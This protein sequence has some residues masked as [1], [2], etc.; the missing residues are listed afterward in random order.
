MIQPGQQASLHGRAL[1]FYDLQPS[2][3]LLHPKLV[4]LSVN[5]DFFNGAITGYLRFQTLH[6]MDREGHFDPIVVTGP[7]DARSSGLIDEQGLNFALSPSLPPLSSTTEPR[8]WEPSLMGVTPLPS[9]QSI[10][11]PCA[12]P[13]GFVVPQG[14]GNLQ[15]G[16]QR[17]LFPSAL[18]HPNSNCALPSGNIFTTACGEQIYY[19]TDDGPIVFSPGQEEARARFAARGRVEFNNPPPPQA[20]VQHGPHGVTLASCNAMRPLCFDAHANQY[21]LSAEGHAQLAEEQ[22]C[23]VLQRSQAPSQLSSLSA[24]TTFEMGSQQVP[25]QQPPQQQSVQQQRSLSQHSER[26]SCAPSPSNRNVR[27]RSN[28]PPPLQQQQQ[29]QQPDQQLSQQQQCMQ[30]PQAAVPQLAPQHA[31]AARFREAGTT[32]ACAVPM[33]PHAQPRACSFAPTQPN[34]Q[35]L[36]THNM[37]MSG[38]APSAPTPPAPPPLPPPVPPVPAMG[39]PS[40]PPPSQG[41]AVSPAPQPYVASLLS[42]LE[43]AGQTASISTLLLSCASALLDVGMVSLLFKADGTPDVHL[44][45]AAVEDGLRAIA[46]SHSPPRPCTDL[47][48]NPVDGTVYQQAVSAFRRFYTASKN[49]TLPPAQLDTTPPQPTP[50]SNAPVQPQQALAPSRPSRPVASVPADQ[51]GVAVHT[52]LLLDRVA[53]DTTDANQMEAL[54]HLLKSNGPNDPQFQDA[55]K[56]ASPNVSALL[57]LDVELVQPEGHG[58]V[59]ETYMYARVLVKA[60]GAAVREVLRE[61]ERMLVPANVEPAP[62]FE[63]FTRFIQAGQLLNITEAVI[64]A[65]PNASSKLLFAGGFTEADKSKAFTRVEVVLKSF[66]EA[67]PAQKMQVSR[68][69]RYFELLCKECI[70]ARIEMKTLHDSVWVPFA[71]AT[72]RRFQDSREVI[73]G[74]T[75]L[76]L[77]SDFADDSPLIRKLFRSHAFSQH[78]R[79]V[80]LPP[81][82]PLAPAAAAPAHRVAAP[83]AAPPLRPQARPPANAQLLCNPLFPNQPNFQSLP[84]PRPPHKPM[85]NI[86][87]RGWAAGKCSFGTACKFMHPGY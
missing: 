75:P 41:A 6:T 24:A 34:A 48:P 36:Q 14:V 74:P 5:Q 11:P 45:R 38:I 68:A 55:V 30:Q 29:V 21:T 80:L 37:C 78:S 26:T 25:Q 82:S 19:P 12:G 81:P 52:A 53:A 23:A 33:A 16:V 13:P 62:E 65:Q 3:P 17:N 39:P 66:G 60:R 18:Q 27:R 22:A 76:L 43:A 4:V 20:S 32:Q 77:A 10:V 56:D 8:G 1:N 51:K 15:Q 58:R 9:Y 50:A 46:A 70:E 79:P 54:A 85:I 67:Y 71:R 61:R 87:C 73:G 64:A 44:L 28:T 63:K 59:Y 83:P 40:Y 47:A 31:A 69:L 72:Q 42:G 84:N 2:N 49:N 86:D 7:L 35:V 57:G